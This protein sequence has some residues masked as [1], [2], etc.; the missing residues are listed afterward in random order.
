MPLRID[1]LAL[2][3][4][5]PIATCEAGPVRNNVSQPS[6]GHVIMFTAAAVGW[7][8]LFLVKLTAFVPGAAWWIQVVFSGTL[9]LASGVF[10]VLLWR[11]VVRRR[12]A[13]GKS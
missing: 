10:A 8:V 9:M 5:D 2:V 12:D 3:L 1:G 13:T 4:V 6:I 11:R 7:L